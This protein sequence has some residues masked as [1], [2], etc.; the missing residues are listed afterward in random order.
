MP[1][2]DWTSATS[3]YPSAM[4]TVPMAEHQRCTLPQL[5]EILAPASGPQVIANKYSGKYFTPGLLR[6]APLVGK[7]LERA[8]SSGSPQTGKQRSTRHMTDSGGLLV[9]DFDKSDRTQVDRIAARLESECI[10]YFLFTSWSIGLP[11][12]PGYRVRILIPVDA[13]LDGAA[14][15]Q[16]WHAC[17]KTLFESAGDPSGDKLCQQQGCWAIGPGRE[18]FAER[19]IFIGGVA[20]V[21]ALTP[22]VPQIGHRVATP[23][24]QAIGKTLHWDGPHPSLKQI[25][26]AVAVMDPDNYSHWDRTICLLIAISKGHGMDTAQLLRIALD[27]ENRS[28]QISRSKNDSPQYST[29]ARF[30]NWTPAITP[31]IAAASLFAMARDTAEQTYRKAVQTHVWAG[32]KP[33]WTYLAGY[34]PKRWSEIR[35]ESEVQV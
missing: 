26:M 29:P 1:L 18:K 20:S 8:K 17:N 6:V 10:S 24:R 14:Y 16:T 12:K 21:K 30:A 19:R 9:F 27:F 23:I 32:A 7:T 15:K 35:A 5:A 34:H 28:A 33:A 4:Q 2:A 25:A 11:E 13:D 31:S 22:T 3:I